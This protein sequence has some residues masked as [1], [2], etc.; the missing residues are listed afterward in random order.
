M[1][2]KYLNI[3]YYDEYGKF[4]FTKWFKW[5]I[6]YKISYLLESAQHHKISI[7]LGFSYFVLDLL[8]ELAEFN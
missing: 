1:D 2:E 4:E 6:H 7:Q 5:K 8:D 3:P